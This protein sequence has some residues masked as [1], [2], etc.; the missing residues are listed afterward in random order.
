[1]C[2]KEED[3]CFNQSLKNQRVFPDLIK[4]S[5]FNKD[6]EPNF[7][8]GIVIG[9]EPGQFSDHFSTSNSCCVKSY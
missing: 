9:K 8:G 1:M 2:Q 3:G 4:T 7:W 6:E 5:D